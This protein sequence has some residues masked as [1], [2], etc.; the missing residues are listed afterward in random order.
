M[1]V[2]RNCTLV[3]AWKKLVQKTAMP[4]II[5]GLPWCT[6]DKLYKGRVGQVA[7]LAELST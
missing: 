1:R 6:V 3:I 5:E 4:G 2:K 7:G